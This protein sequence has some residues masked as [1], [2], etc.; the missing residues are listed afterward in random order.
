M[1]QD[2][3]EAKIMEKKRQRL[4][5]QQHGNKGEAKGEP[6][7]LDVQAFKEVVKNS[8]QPVFIDFWAPWCAPCRMTEPI[9]E[10]LAEDFK[11][12]VVV[13]KLNLEED[14]NRSIAQKY[15][16]AAIPTFLVFKNGKPVERIIGA[17]N[18]EAFKETIQKHL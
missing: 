5:D 3:E 1:S 11:G 10:D 13:G 6:I 14:N 18:K 17:R 16:V 9:V 8:E 15:Q 12:K 7:H 2:N 4:M